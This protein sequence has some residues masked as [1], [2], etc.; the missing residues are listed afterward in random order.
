MLVWSERASEPYLSPI[1]IHNIKQKLAGVIFR[2]EMM[3]VY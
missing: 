2:Y 1:G 3:S